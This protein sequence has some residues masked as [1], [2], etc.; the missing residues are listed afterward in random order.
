M[1]TEVTFRRKKYKLIITQHALERMAQRDIPRSIV[2]EII[3]TG[4]SKAKKKP[5]KWWVYK[6][7]KGRK[8]NNV[9]LS[10]SIEE[11]HLI[12]ITT[13]VDWRPK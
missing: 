13:L 10:I 2:Q 6:K 5:G 1:L 9:S 3:E 4:K 12:V 11:P 8:D 7:I